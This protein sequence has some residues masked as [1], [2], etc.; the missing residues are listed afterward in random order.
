MRDRPN[1]AELLAEAWRVLSQDL[2]PGLT[3]EQRYKVLL[4]ASAVAIVQRELAAGDEP[5]E[6]EAQALTDL[7]GSGGSLLDLNAD[8][9]AAVRSGKFDRSSE[10]YAVLRKTVEARVSE[11][12]P[13]AL[14]L[15][16]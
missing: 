3:G 5:A 12:N 6:A 9:A 13:T 10:V 2:A 11:S 7:L 14:D 8:L 16:T 15:S 1:G 4:V